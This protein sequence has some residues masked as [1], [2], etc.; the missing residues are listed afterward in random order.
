LVAEGNTREHRLSARRCP[1][2]G[3]IVGGKTAI[4]KLK[5]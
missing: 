2:A 3:E 1:P 5:F 4:V